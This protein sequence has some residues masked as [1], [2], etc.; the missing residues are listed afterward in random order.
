[1]ILKKLAFC[2][3]V[4]LLAAAGT[5]C[6]AQPGTAEPENGVTLRKSTVQ[7]FGDG[8]R[9]TTTLYMTPTR[10]RESS[11][12]GSDFLLFLDRSMFVT[13]YHS[14][15]TYT[16]L[17]FDELEQLINE[18]KDEMSRGEKAKA[19]QAMR[20]RVQQTGD[21]ATVHDL[22]AGTEMVGFSTRHHRIELPPVTLEMWTT[23]ELK[24]PEA[25]YDSLRLRALANP[26]L[27]LDPLYEALKGIEGLSLRSIMMIDAVDMKI[28]STSEVTEIVRGPIPDVIFD[29]P[30]GYTKKEAT[31]SQ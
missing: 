30:E 26:V 29:V 18:V 22:G 25:Y 16:E 17:T 11:S 23:P 15:R 1:M 4:C 10:V 27:D 24:V 28:Q 21:E 19:Q 8:Q 14:S 5:F 3:G 12:N 7:A 31:A 9:H 6:T 2:S 20:D 13:L